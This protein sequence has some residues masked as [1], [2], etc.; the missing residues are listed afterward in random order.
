MNTQ[1][2]VMDEGEKGLEIN[3]NIVQFSTPEDQA[4]HNIK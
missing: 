3:I 4:A 1:D 2:K